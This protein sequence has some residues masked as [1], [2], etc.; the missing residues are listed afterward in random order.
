[1]VGELSDIWQM[2]AI[3]NPGDPFV[4]P[5]KVEIRECRFDAPGAG[6]R[7]LANGACSVR[8][9]CIAKKV[10]RHSGKPR[11]RVHARMCGWREDAWSDLAH[12]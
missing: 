9:W 3:L 7:K 4:L 1:M 12:R 2:K 11:A 5:R 8:G 6:G 10:S